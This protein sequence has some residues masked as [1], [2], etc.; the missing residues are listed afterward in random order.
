MK[1]KRNVQPRILHPPTLSFRFDW[2][3]KSFM[4]KQ[5]LKE[6]GIKKPALQQMSK[7]PLQAIKE[8][9]QLETANQE[10]KISQVKANIQ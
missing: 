7:E 4:D 8:R 9:P 1:G 10:M 2:D 6:F 3:I 5:K